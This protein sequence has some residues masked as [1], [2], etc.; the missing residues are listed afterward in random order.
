[1]NKKFS[2]L[3]SI[4]SKEQPEYF[5]IAMESIWNS[6]ILKPYEIV[7]VQDGPLPEELHIEIQKWSNILK[8]KLIIVVQKENMG[9]AISLNNGIQYCT[10]DYIAR[11]DTDDVSHS[12]RFLKQ[13]D[14]MN[15]NLEI[16]IVGS[17]IDEI[18]EL[19]VLI[20]KGVKYPLNDE[21]CFKF[22]KKR[23]PVAHPA[24]MFRKT[25]F[26][27]A[28]FYDE[29]FRMAQDTILWYQGFLSGCKFSNIQESLL[30][31]RRSSDLYERRSNKKKARMLLSHRF[32]KINRDLKY[33]LIGDIYAILYYLLTMSPSFIKKILY[34]KLR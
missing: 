12:D 25:F 29:K 24:V 33:G 21:D 32:F 10:C 27:K 3:L 1:M 19:G 11:M 2:V 4:Y 30:S 22:F 23:D 8:D 13:I 28:G 15:K 5:A 20:K 34:T 26:E 18:N 14:F 7:L 16:D 31:F 6:Q 9:L 17:A